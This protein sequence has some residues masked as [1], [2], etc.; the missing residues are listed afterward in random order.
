MQGWAV[1][2]FSLFFYPVVLPRGLQAESPQSSEAPNNLIRIFDSHSGKFITE[3]PVVKT[4]AEW[5]QQLTPAQYRITR[6]AG[7]EPPF[8]NEHFHEGE[9][10]TYQCVGCG[11][12]L[13]ASETKYASGTGWPSFWKPVAKE[14]IV[15][16]PDYHLFMH[17]T[18]VLCARC[19]AHLG[20]V[21][22]DG[23]PPTHQ[24]YCMN[25]GALQFLPAKTE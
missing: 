24:R 23:P 25:A 18:E 11:T 13:F 5:K 21:F 22:D 20:H 6:E 14:N 9:K 2:L 16:K 19:G 1:I 4:E 3:E 7:T 17:R 15:L 10:G 12:D 8:T